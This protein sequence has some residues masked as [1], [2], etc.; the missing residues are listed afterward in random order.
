LNENSVSDIINPIYFLF[1]V[2]FTNW[3]VRV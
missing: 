1:D 3:S 2:M